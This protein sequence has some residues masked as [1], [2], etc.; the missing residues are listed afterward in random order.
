M[1]CGKL[2]QDD[3]VPSRSD[4][5]GQGEEQDE[6]GRLDTR[7]KE[8]GVRFLSERTLSSPVCVLVSP[9]CDFEDVVFTGARSVDSRALRGGCASRAI[10]SKLSRDV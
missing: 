9:S 10:T 7:R 4:N 1:V 5:H 6:E 2:L 8:R 3:G